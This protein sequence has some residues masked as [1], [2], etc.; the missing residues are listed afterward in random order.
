MHNL[1]SMHN[2]VQFGAILATIGLIIVAALMA[3][4]VFV[5]VKLVD[6]LRVLKTLAWCLGVFF[7]GIVGLSLMMFM[8]PAN[9]VTTVTKHKQAA[10]EAISFARAEAAGSLP[11][12]PRLVAS[13]AFSAISVRDEQPTTSAW[14]E[15]IAPVANICLL[16][17]SPSPRDQRGSRMPSSA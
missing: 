14:D 16:Y 2:Q 15:N 6:R 7:L 13:N 5:F 11:D 17:T 9:A 3:L 12:H 10:T 4:A 8:V 1:V